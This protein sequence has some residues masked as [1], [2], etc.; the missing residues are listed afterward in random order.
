MCIA[1]IETVGKGLLERQG[2]LIEA[3]EALAPGATTC[4]T[5]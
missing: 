2:E 4:S 1:Q 5:R 3:M